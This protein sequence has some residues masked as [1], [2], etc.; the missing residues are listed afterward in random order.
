MTHRHGGSSWPDGEASVQ[1]LAQGL[2]WFSIGLGLAE[3]LAPQS[4][5]RYL[6]M[7]QPAGL[8]RLYGMREIMTGLGI[9]SQRDP[10]PWIWA[11]VGG[12]AVDLATLATGLHPHNPRRG[13]VVVATAG[14]ACV[15]ALDA[16]CA[17]RLSSL[18]QARASARRRLRAR[19]YSKRRGMPRAPEAMRGAASD[20]DL[21]KDMRIPEA[22]RPYPTRNPP[23]ADG[24]VATDPDYRSP[25]AE[26]AIRV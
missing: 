9:L 3:L 25:T 19:D 1:A 11:R 15:T 24:T 4:I 7:R 16:I 21:P 5:A 20:F 2:G 12:D 13:N 18:H 6:G 23:P 8:I 26:L 10:T 14:V 22:M 17:E